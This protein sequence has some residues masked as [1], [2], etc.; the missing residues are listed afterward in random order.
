MTTVIGNAYL[1]P[2]VNCGVW[3]QLFVETAI[4]YVHLHKYLWF[5]R[6]LVL[7][8]LDVTIGDKPLSELMLT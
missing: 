1:F 8:S 7:L 3:C 6:I 4:N 2:Y 5:D